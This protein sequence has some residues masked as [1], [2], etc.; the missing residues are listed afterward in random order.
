MTGSSLKFSNMKMTK[1]MTPITISSFCIF[2]TSAF[3]PRLSAQCSSCVTRNS[4]TKMNKMNR[5]KTTLAVKTC[6]SL[7]MPNTDAGLTCPPPWL[8]SVCPDAW[9]SSPWLVDDAWAASP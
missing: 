3:K 5:T 8:S 7:M 1:E 9:A 4:K 2:S 6:R